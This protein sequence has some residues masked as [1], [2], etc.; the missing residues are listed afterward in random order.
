MPQS[1]NSSPPADEKELQPIE[2]SPDSDDELEVKNKKRKAGRESPLTDEQKAV[3]D[4]YIPAWETLLTKFKL[5]LRKD[6]KGRDDEEVTGWISTTV[7]AI[8]K[9]P[10]FSS[11]AVARTSGDWN[12]V[13][14]V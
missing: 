7:K 9:R 8:I 12:K 5:H 1:P 3:V 11:S 10:E 4:G 2:D 6:G 14:E 13:S